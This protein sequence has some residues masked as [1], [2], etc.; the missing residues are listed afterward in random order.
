MNEV[1]SK[2]RRITLEQGELLAKTFGAV[3]YV[4]CSAVTQ[5]GLKNMFDEVSNSL[6]FNWV[7]ELI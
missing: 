4:E 7:V 5:T 1:H 6:F 2:A 3:K